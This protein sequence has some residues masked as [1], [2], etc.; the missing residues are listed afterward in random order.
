MTDIETAIKRIECGIGYGVFYLAHGLAID[1]AKA[2][3]EEWSRLAAKG[4]IE[5]TKLYPEKMYNKDMPLLQHTY[6]LL[7]GLSFCIDVNADSAIVYIGI[8]NDVEPRNR[9][10]IQA[11]FEWQ[12]YGVSKE[13]INIPAR[14]IF[15]D[16]LGQVKLAK[17]VKIGIKKRNL[18]SMQ[19]NFDNGFDKGRTQRYTDPA[20]IMRNAKKSIPHKVLVG[21]ISNY[22]TGELRWL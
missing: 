10:S 18:E 6:T 22:N 8:D 5:Y 17:S 14:P 21:K 12:T 16:V 1:G 7:R 20:V 11:V 15:Y 3:A 4:M 2:I 13:K 19:Y 9:A